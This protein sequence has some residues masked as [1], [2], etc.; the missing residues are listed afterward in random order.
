MIV[1]TYD[2]AVGLPEQEWTGTRDHVTRGVLHD[3]E[4]AEMLA[5]ADVPGRVTLNS[6]YA[7]GAA[8][9]TGWFLVWHMDDGTVQAAEFT[10][11]P[12]PADTA[13]TDPHW[14]A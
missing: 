7:D 14:T 8:L 11:H 6:V 12:A 4:Y 1:K 13:A 9:P 3:L 5:G 2:D 10:V